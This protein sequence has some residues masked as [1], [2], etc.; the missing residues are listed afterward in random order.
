MK[1]SILFK[2]ESRKGFGKGASRELRRQG[3]L[4]GVLYGKGQEPISFSL[5]E[6]AFV[7]QFQKGGITHK[8]AKI[9]LDGKEY[10]VLPREV[11]LHPVSDKP[12]HVDFL[13]VD[14]KSRVRVDIPVRVLN[15]D[16]CAGVKLGGAIN[17]VR[18]EIEMLCVPDSI[19]SYIEVDV[20]EMEIGDSLHISHVTLP[21]GVTPT[22]T[23]RDFTII[24]VAG[25]KADTDG[26]ADA[27]AAAAAAAAGAA[28][29]PGAVAAPAA[30]GAAG[31]AAPKAAP[32]K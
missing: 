11:Q 31:A 15:A 3:R 7:L 20:L 2:A 6:R 4:P 17:I 13:K 28:A 12:E 21:E 25:R 30:A 9:E 32:K 16:K 10:F 19:P 22:I 1:T 8:L 18:H 29:A 5:D 27:A 24:T 23:D 26:A 14:A